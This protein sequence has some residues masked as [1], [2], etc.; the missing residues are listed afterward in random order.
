MPDCPTKIALK[1]QGALIENL[2]T[3]RDASDLTGLSMAW[4]ERKRWEGAGPPW[5]KVGGP[6]GRAV[7]YRK[8]DL[9]AWFEAN[10]VTPSNA[11][12]G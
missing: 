10:L 5:V 12:R 7:R 6:S 8:S 3:T 9:L 11:I 4:F 1:H 2:I